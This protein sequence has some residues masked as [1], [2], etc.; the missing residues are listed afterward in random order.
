MTFNR[1]PGAPDASSIDITEFLSVAPVGSKIKCRVT[2]DGFEGPDEPITIALDTQDVL[3]QEAAEP[4]SAVPVIDSVDIL[5]ASEGARAVAE[6]LITYDGDFAAD[7]WSIEWNWS[8]EVED[9][10]GELPFVDLTY[11]VTTDYKYR[12]NDESGFG[13]LKSQPRNIT[14]KTITWRIGSNNPIEHGTF[15]DGSPWVKDNG[16]LHLISVTPEPGLFTDRVRGEFT[17]GGHDPAVYP[18]G[19]KTFNPGH[20]RSERDW[21]TNQTVINPDFGKSTTEYAGQQVL[22]PNGEIRNW[23]YTDK[24]DWVTRC[25]TT[26]DGNEN[27]PV[28][29]GGDLSDPRFMFPMDGRSGIT[30]KQWNNYQGKGATIKV[31]E[32]YAT[33]TGQIWDRSR[34]KIENGDMIFSCISHADDTELIETVDKFDDDGNYTHTEW[35]DHTMWG[36]FD[37]E[38]IFDLFGCLTVVDRDREGFYRPPINWDPSDKENRPFIQPSRTKAELD[39]LNYDYP[40]YGIYEG[41][42]AGYGDADKLGEWF[43]LS[44][45]TTDN[46]EDI[47]PLRLGSI[48]VMPGGTQHDDMVQGWTRSFCTNWW[49]WGGTEGVMIEIM[50]MM[51]FDNREDESIRDQLRHVLTQRGIDIYGAFRSLGKWS[52]SNGGHSEPYDWYLLYAWMMTQ[53]VDILNAING[54]PIGMDRNG[55]LKTLDQ[56]NEGISR[57]GARRQQVVKQDPQATRHNCRINDLN[58][59]ATGVTD[60]SHEFG[61]GIH[62]IEVEPPLSNLVGQGNPHTRYY[63]VSG[64]DNRST[65]GSTPTSLGTWGRWGM[66]NN[67]KEI[68]RNKFIGFY[69]R[70][71]SGG[72]TRVIASEGNVDPQKNSYGGTWFTDTPQRFYLQK[73]IGV[74]AGQTI[75]LSPFVVEDL[76]GGANR[77]FFTAINPANL[78]S[79][80]GTHNYIHTNMRNQVILPFIADHLLANLGGGENSLPDFWKPLYQYS[81]LWWKD[82]ILNSAIIGEG[83]WFSGT[84]YTSTRQNQANQKEIMRSLVR[85]FTL[86]GEPAVPNY[87]NPIDKVNN[88]PDGDYTWP[89]I[90]ND[91][92]DSGGNVRS[93]TPS[94]FI[95]WPDDNRIDKGGSNRAVEDPDGNL[96]ENIDGNTPSVIDIFQRTI[97]SSG[98]DALFV[99]SRGNESV[100]YSQYINGRNLYLWINGAEKPIRMELQEETITEDFIWEQTW[101]FPDEIRVW[102]NTTHQWTDKIDGQVFWATDS[103]SGGSAEWPAEVWRIQSGETFTDTEHDNNIWSFEDYAAV[104][105]PWANTPEHRPIIL[106]KPKNANEVISVLNYCQSNDVPFKVRSGTHSY[107]AQGTGLGAVIIDMRLIDEC[108]L[109]TTDEWMDIGGGAA[110]WQVNAELNYD[111]LAPNTSTPSAYGDE[112]TGEYTNNSPDDP[113]GYWTPSGSC[114]R[115]GYSGV[116]S[117]GGISV[118]PNREGLMCDLIL[119]ADVVIPDGMNGYRMVTATRENEFSDLLDGLRGL[120]ND[121]LGIVTRWRTKVLPRKKEWT[122]RLGL[123]W[124][125]QGGSWFKQT[126]Q[127]LWAVKGTDAAVGSPEWTAHWQ[128]VQNSDEWAWI[129]AVYEAYQDTLMDTTA[130]YPAGHPIAGR[131]IWPHGRDEGIDGTSYVWLNYKRPEDT[132]NDYSITA[133]F[134][135]WSY[136]DPEGLMVSTSAGDVPA[137][138]YYLTQ[139]ILDRAI[140]KDPS[141]FD[142]FRSGTKNGATV[143]ALWQVTVNEAKDQGVNS[144]T[145]DMW[146]PEQDAP[147]DTNKQVNGATDDQVWGLNY[148]LCIPNNSP[149]DAAFVERLMQY[150]QDIVIN[151][152]PFLPDGGT[153]KQGVYHRY[154]THSSSPDGPVANPQI[155]T[156]DTSRD[157][158]GWRDRP[159]EIQMFEELHPTSSFF[160][161]QNASGNYELTDLGHQFYDMKI[162]WFDD[163]ISLYGGNDPRSYIGYIDS[164][165]NYA[166]LPNG[167]PLDINQFY[168]GIQGVQNLTNLKAKYDPQERFPFGPQTKTI[169]VNTT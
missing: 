6:A 84:T 99:R 55:T 85:K 110:L 7:G 66:R 146:N 121:S 96:V 44:R 75:D 163:A 42:S 31:G 72:I 79:L 93:L 165:W 20:V 97:G 128:N 89:E 73:N 52:S 11:S 82:P 78:G 132:W 36:S 61:A 151:I 30:G 162:K 92:E 126:D 133:P 1:L 4:P 14:T 105:R 149:N 159:N 155:V 138:L 58:V 64:N 51:S 38:P 80:G 112:D 21:E 57:I 5:Q 45:P 32:S 137:H 56:F 109:N 156:H 41:E 117:S 87:S 81:T 116:A 54:T 153:G 115:V 16:D 154:Y 135:F 119:E 160:W 35:R 34:T 148:A 143:D 22:L 106:A 67:Q 49:E 101:V 134:R 118:N 3:I 161:Q 9:S 167:Q 125:P 103:S 74:D 100:S 43:N 39:A 25:K 169:D 157:V 60:S 83:A 53:D 120:G 50:I 48:R 24:S 63:H 94:L 127:N 144:S 26:S 76:D 98:Q 86:K 152:N 123:A 27:E 122:V 129:K 141:R 29:L 158:L 164:L 140:A 71:S 70:S 17:E 62:Y 91:Y 104:T 142:R 47:T 88:W 77:A 33:S 68:N 59:L 139:F 18:G 40:D 90:S 65:G 150:Y 10:G 69:I 37:R 166:T 113:N 95:E 12:V 23:P 130:T 15:L 145:N 28:I 147:N 131:R 168:Y 114:P 111:K 136:E 108:S 46:N 8:R 2:A 19:V 124:R 102:P 107:N 13:F